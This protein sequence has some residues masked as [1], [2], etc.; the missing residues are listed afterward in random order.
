MEII[1]VV[2]AHKIYVNFSK[3]HIGYTPHTRTHMHTHVCKIVSLIFRVYISR[4][5]TYVPQ[6]I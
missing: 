4:T 5:Q 3:E 2:V 6:N 1:A